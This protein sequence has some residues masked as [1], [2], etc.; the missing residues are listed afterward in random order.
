[1]TDETTD[2]ADG[3]TAPPDAPL[4]DDEEALQAEE[5]GGES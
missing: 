4:L 5:K 3:A 2:Q 1:M